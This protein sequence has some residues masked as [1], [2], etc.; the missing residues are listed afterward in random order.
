MNTNAES[1][2]T[3]GCGRCP[4]G[5]TP[6]CKVNNW[7]QELLTI[8]SII[9]ECGLTEVSKWGVPCYTYQ[10]KNILL[11]GAFKDYCV[12]SF[13]KGVLLEDTHQVL[14][15]PGENSQSGRII[16]ITEVAQVMRLQQVIKNYIYQ[17]IDIETSGKKVK[18][19]TIEEYYVAPEFENKLNAMP[20]LKSAFETLTPGK[21]RGYLIYINSAKQQQTRESRIEKCIPMILQGKAFN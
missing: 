15:L 5:G 12:I 3:E 18:L 16:R 7:T 1:Y 20:E 2:F 21:R 19:K 9:Q 11:L 6:A 17:A 8:R 14:E 4:L 10:N 13:L